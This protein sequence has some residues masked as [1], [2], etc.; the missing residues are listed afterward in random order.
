MDLFEYVSMAKYEK[1]REEAKCEAGSVNYDYAQKIRK[2]ICGDNEGLNKQFEEYEH[3][4]VRQFEEENDLINMKY[5]CEGVK[6]GMELQRYFN[7]E[8]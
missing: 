5:L 1:W 4:L 6:I 8:E 2:K 3:E 7:E